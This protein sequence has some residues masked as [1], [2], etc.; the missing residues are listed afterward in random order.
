VSGQL[1]YVNPFERLGEL[2]SDLR[3]SLVAELPANAYTGQLLGTLAGLIT[4]AEHL[5]VMVATLERHDPV[6]FEVFQ[7][8]VTR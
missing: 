2:L 3:R 8:V 4:Q 1:V 7:R 6:A 5:R